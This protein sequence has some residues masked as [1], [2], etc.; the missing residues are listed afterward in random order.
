MPLGKVAENESRETKPAS[1]VVK[2]LSKY[3]NL[4]LKK[5]NDLIRMLIKI[6]Q[7]K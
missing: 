6:L 4:F 3:K 2:M 1:E 7:S 5:K